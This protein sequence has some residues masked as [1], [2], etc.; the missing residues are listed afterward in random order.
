MVV[1]RFSTIRPTAVEASAR[2]MLAMLHTKDVL[3]NDVWHK[4]SIKTRPLQRELRC[5]ETDMAGKRLL[6]KMVKWSRPASLLGRGPRYSLLP[7]TRD[8]NSE[9]VMALRRKM[10]R[11]AE[12]TKLEPGFLM[13][14]MVRQRCSA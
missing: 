5:Q 7:W 13:P 12:V 10:P 9:R 14:R 11:V 2:K 1:M 4:G 8:R 6:Y 3:L